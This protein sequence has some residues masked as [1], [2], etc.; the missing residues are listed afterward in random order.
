M[1]AHWCLHYHDSWLWH[2]N[3]DS[4]KHFRQFVMLFL[5][6][7]FSWWRRFF[8]FCSCFYSLKHTRNREKTLLLNAN[9]VSKQKKYYIIIFNACRG[10]QQQRTL[11]H[12]IHISPLG[13]LLSSHVKTIIKLYTDRECILFCV[14]L[15]SSI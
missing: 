9:E 6:D 15:L 10:T 3:I 4:I 12:L 5:N 2:D 8:L 1:H 11:L 7:V 14:S 13:V